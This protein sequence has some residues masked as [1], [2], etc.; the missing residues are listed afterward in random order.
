VLSL[1][2]YRQA[3]KI[4]FLHSCNVADFSTFPRLAT[5]LNTSAKVFVFMATGS[6]R[7]EEPKVKIKNVEHTICVNVIFDV[8]AVAIR[9]S[10][11]WRSKLTAVWRPRR[12][13]LRL[14]DSIKAG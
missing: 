9:A 3:E 2:E 10:L 7:A 14:Y 13:A 6:Q 1:I 4:I 12:I 11:L 8:V 5:S